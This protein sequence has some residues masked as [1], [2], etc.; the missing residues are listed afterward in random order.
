VETLN[1]DILV[2]G[3]GIAGLSFALRVADAAD[4]IIVTKKEQSASNTN[5]A[6]G[7]I[8]SVLANTDSFEEHVADT[9]RA[10]AGLCREA[11]VREVVE[12]GPRAVQDLIDWGVA[13]SR[14]S[15]AVGA[16]FDLGL[17]GG[18]SHARVVHAGDFTGREIETALLA[19]AVAHP[20]V[21]ILEHHLATRLLCLPIGTAGVTRC[22]GADVL[23]RSKTR[24]IRI[25]ARAVL[26]ASGGSG[27]VYQH[28]TNPEIATGD[29]LALAY[30]AG[31]RVANLEFMQFHPT[32]LYHPGAAPFLISEAVRGEGG[33]L[34]NGSG[35]A[36]MQGYHPKAD[37]A[38]RD[39]VARA[40]DQEMKKSGAPCVHLDITHVSRQ[41]LETRFPNIYARLYR[42]GI[43]LA[44][45]PV[46][47]VP[48]AH[49]LCGGVLC[50]LDGHTSIEGLFVSGEVACT[51]MHGANRL[52]SNS[53]LEAVVLS[54]RAAAHLRA[55]LPEAPPPAADFPP[56]ANGRAQPPGVLIAHVRRD[57]TQIMWDY[58]GIVRT[59]RRLDWARRNLQRLR[60][61]ADL[62]VEESGP[63]YELAE[64]DNILTN[65]TLMVE[66]ARRRQE[67][68]GLRY[69]TDCPTATDAHPGQ[70]TVLQRGERDVTA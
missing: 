56:P 45:D 61:E 5:Y 33:I 63:G 21:R 13:F 34:R 4:V 23:S 31:A 49:Y 40:I 24:R 47:V 68:R 64:L 6:Q 67:S 29:G 32:S 52:A 42:Y 17:E 16:G 20:R 28:T 53:L 12:E 62:L 10:G 22:L 44:A 69:N 25:V 14:A 46:P 60:G 35:E 36:F 39:V 41:R 19:Q 26:L 57:V 27:R 38:P 2:I 66:C 50:D 59:H 15:A 55:N 58:V 3:S 48:A 9:L 51:G 30:H 7:G 1:T 70:D 37:L 8:A 11:V 54:A 18:H 43:D 65:A